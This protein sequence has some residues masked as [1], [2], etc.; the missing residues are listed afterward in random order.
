MAQVK[1]KKVLTKVQKY[2][3][4]NIEKVAP[5]IDGGQF[6]IKRVVGEHVVVRASVYADGHDEIAVRL[7]YRPVASADWQY[8]EMTS[9]GN[10]RWEACFDISQMTDYVY[11]IQGCIDV[12]TSW[13]RDLKKKWDA[14]APVDI[15]IL[16]G[17]Q[18]MEQ[19]LEKA[20]GKDGD[21]LRDLMQQLRSPKVTPEGMALAFSD[22]LQKLMR[23]YV[24]WANGCAYPKE[25]RVTVDR[26]KALFSAWYEFFPRSWG[27]DGRHGSFKD[28]EKMLPEIARMGFD[29]VYFPPI[30]PIGI[31]NRKGTNNS[32]ICEPQDPGCPWAIGNKEGG[33][34]SIHPQLGTLNDLKHFIKEARAYGIDVALDLAYQCSPDHPYVKEHPEWFKW[35]PDGSIQFA[36]N[37]PKKYEDVLPLNF[38]TADWKNL[39]DELKS[40]VLFWIDQGIR[41]FRVDNPHTK[42]FAFWD[43]LISE[44]KKD[45]PDTLFLAEAFTRPHVMYRLA[46]GGFS[47]SYTYFT[48]RN[49]KE[50][51]VD[52]LTE[53]TQS[54]VQDYFRPNFWPNTPDILPVHLQSG[55]RPAFMARLVLAATL[56]SNYGIYGPVFEL[57]VSEAVPNKEEYF[58]SEKYALKSWAWD[59]EGHLKDVIARINQIRRENPALHE[60]GNIRFCETSNDFLLSYYKCS[61]DGQN[62]ILVVVNI[63][64]YH[65]QSGM[66]KIPLDRWNIE[67]QRPFL[68]HD[69]LSN[70]RYIWQGETNYIELNPQISPAHVIRVRPHLHREQD[71]DYFM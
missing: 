34:K 56:S 22:E 51:F 40:V 54:E 64:P 35:R 61:P 55:G 50:E 37:P 57:C 49:T 16:V 17:V 26:K 29:V 15:D 7:A 45:Y 11:T 20:Q 18:L 31:T 3:R 70:D 43:W 39:W 58:D 23:S 27:P 59:Q 65:T 10:D 38:E 71:F 68:A 52:Y 47:Q 48:W 41:I 9:L 14:Q 21:Y 30:H 66:V 5:E 28:C 4:V 19:V 6:A 12:F 8:R 32:V 36:E 69:L 33:H 60:T 62:I 46:K 1:T 13:Q 53:L 25:L 63:D 24:E 44:I 67:Q 42:P 2:S